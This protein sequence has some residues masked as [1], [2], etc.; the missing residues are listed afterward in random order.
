MG[1]G[2]RAGKM[3]EGSMFGKERESGKVRGRA[4]VWK[5]EVRGR[6]KWEG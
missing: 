1:E 3:G 4:K 5:G 2:R 6:G